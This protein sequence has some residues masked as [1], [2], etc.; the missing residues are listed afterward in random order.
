[1]IIEKMRPEHTLQVLALQQTLVPFELSASHAQSVYEN[2]YHDTDYYLAVA[3]ED[4]TIL[5][6]ATGIICHGL[7]GNFLVIEDFVVKESLRGKGI[8][9]KL[10]QKLDEFAISRNCIYAI[11]VSSGFRKNAHRFYE[12]CG[13]H[14]DVRGF[15][16]NY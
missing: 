9:T 7:G 12:K 4:D 3:R 13:F 10:M 16:K 11:L 14:D 6:T 5:G 15:R 2:L 1:M 8:G